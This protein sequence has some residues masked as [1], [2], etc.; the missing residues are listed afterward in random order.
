M[1]VLIDKAIPKHKYT[2]RELNTKFYK[3]ALLAA[4]ITHSEPAERL[5]PGSGLSWEGFQLGPGT[6]PARRAQDPVGEVI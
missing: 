1:R 3:A 5:P 2:S 6:I 4:C